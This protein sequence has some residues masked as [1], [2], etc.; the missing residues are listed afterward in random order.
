MP[1]CDLDDAQSPNGEPT[2]WT[3]PHWRYSTTYG[4]VH[5]L[6]AQWHTVTGTLLRKVGETYFED[7]DNPSNPD[8]PAESS[9]E[10]RDNPNLPLDQDRDM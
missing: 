1:Q 5:E 2:T 4:F 10:T 9:G 3:D 6:D 8:L 7:E